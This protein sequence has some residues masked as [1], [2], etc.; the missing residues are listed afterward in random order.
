MG[1]VCL[2]DKVVQD[3]LTPPSWTPSGPRGIHKGQS[4]G[5]GLERQYSFSLT[6]SHARNN[7]LSFL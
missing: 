6:A 5:R 3:L 7:L 1:L 2:W 4:R